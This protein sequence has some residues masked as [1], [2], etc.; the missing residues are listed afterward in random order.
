MSVNQALSPP[1]PPDL[2]MYLLARR[3]AVLNN[4]HIACQQDARVPT[5][6]ALAREEFTDMM[7]TIL[8]VLSQRLRGAAEDADPMQVAEEHGLHR[9]HKGYTLRELL[10]ETAHLHRLLSDELQTYWQLYPTTD[11]G[12]LL[13]AYREII[14]LNHEIVEG[15]VASYDE[16]E[17]SSAVSRVETLRSALDQVNEL[18]RQRTDLLRTS[19]HDLRSSFGIIQGAAFMLDFEH[20]NPEERGRLIEMLNRNLTNVQG[21]LQSLMSLA[22]LDA[23]QDPPEISHFDVARLIRELVQSTQ[24][25]AAGRPLT[26]LADGPEELLVDSDPVKIR[27][28]IQNLLVNALTYTTSGIISVS[29]TQENDYRWIVSIQDTGP[30]LPD[31][32]MQLLGGKLKPTQ[33]SNSVL[34]SQSVTDTP[35]RDSPAGPSNGEGVGLHIV[36]QLCEVLQGSLDVETRPGEG[37]LIRVR[38]P[39]HF[40]P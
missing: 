28:I 18:S 13:A 7:P 38:L 20:H 14:R 31:T 9:W 35:V 8:N 25:L 19:S 33:D 21:M 23:G 40:K 27:R 37:T 3:E 15:S 34:D 22:R 6:A 24:T 11:P 26:V 30:G 16:L 29:W 39:V 10:K 4:W 36:K 17:R 32:V 12:L 5:A 2:S 1:T